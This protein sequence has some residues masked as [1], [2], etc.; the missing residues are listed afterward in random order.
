MKA[1]ALG[2]SEKFYRY[3]CGK[4]VGHPRQAARPW[5]GHR[6]VV[7]LVRRSGDRIDARRIR[8]VLFSATNAAAVTC[9]I[10]NPEFSPGFGVRKRGQTR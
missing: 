6:D 8:S 2:S 7:F 10:M 4:V 5:R 9:G 1:A 3:H